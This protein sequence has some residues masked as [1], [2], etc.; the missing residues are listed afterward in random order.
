[1]GG[2]CVKKKTNDYLWAITLFVAA[3]I[4][5][6]FIFFGAA[7][8]SVEKNSKKNTMDI[9]MRQSSHLRSMLEIHYEYLQ[10]V[11]DQLSESEDI[12]S[13]EYLNM[14]A[15]LRDYTELE[16][17]A[18]VEPDGTAHFDNGVVN[19]VSHRRYY[20][21]G[22]QGKQT[23]SDPLESSVNGDT[24]VILGVPIM[25]KQEVV[26]VLGGSYNVTALSRMLLNDAFGGVGYSLI[27]TKDGDIIAYDGDPSYHK[28]NYG[29]NFFE[30]YQGKSLRKGFS[31]E[32]VAEDFSTQQSGLI[33]MYEKHKYKSDQ[34]L[35]YAP[36]GMN[37]WMI[38]YVLPTSVAY[39]PYAFFSNYELMFMSCF[40][41]LVLILVFY[42]IKKNNVKTEELVRSAR[43]D[44][45]TGLYN[46]KATEQ[47]I[48][49]AILTS[50]KSLKQALIILDLDYF[51]QIND[52][53][54]HM[55][56][57]IVLQQFATLLRD[58][59]REGDIV[60]RIGG[61]EFIVFM[62][63]LQSEEIVYKRLEQLIEKVHDL[64]PA[65]LISGLSTSMGV[66]FA[67][68]SGEQYA[69]LYKDAD[70]ALY[71]TKQNGRDGYSVFEKI[72]Q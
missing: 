38:C 43:T 42:I 17:F 56:G 47:L 36:L 20:L 27:V 2:I 34:Y 21:E 16:L 52:T 10:G 50:D 25:K 1:M 58:H 66:A 48:N 8:S 3:I 63:E 40:G 61:D 15:K 22:M 29:D 6:M 13:D 18:L 64:K 45:M 59:F 46:K 65:G 41:V 67:P 5:A 33:K 24:R 28:I 68:S 49:E 11:A 72:E 55:F 60:G 9:V 44:A 39:E 4:V 53:Y 14:L 19:D 30:F 57:D 12:F 37:D 62:R 54:G 71:K 23:L 35:A 31:F 51:K 69:D 7:Q 32:A 70:S 26:G